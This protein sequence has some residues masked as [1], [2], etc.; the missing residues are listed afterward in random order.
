MAGSG[1]PPGGEN[2]LKGGP[3]IYPVVSVGPFAKFSFYPRATVRNMVKRVGFWAAG[4]T[5]LPGTRV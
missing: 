5:I 2:L 4:G 1:P 3:T